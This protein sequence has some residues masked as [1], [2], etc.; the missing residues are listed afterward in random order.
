M[1]F[2]IARE[3]LQEGLSCSSCECAGEDDT[4]CSGEPLGRDYR[5]E[6]FVYPERISIWL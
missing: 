6:G 1:R 4:S 3:K 2:T 5:Y